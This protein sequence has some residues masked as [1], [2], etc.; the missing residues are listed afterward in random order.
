[1]SHYVRAGILSRTV[2]WAA[3]LTV[4]YCLTI[5]AVS[6]GTAVAVAMV[7]GLTTAPLFGV[8]MAVHGK[9]PRIMAADD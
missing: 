5:I 4:A 8:M 1:M 6:A 9:A 2:V 3:L 7:L